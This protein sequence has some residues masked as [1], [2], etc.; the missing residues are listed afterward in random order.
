MGYHKIEPLERL[1]P[2]VESIWIQE[3]LRDASKEAF[4]PTTIIP[5]TRIDMLF[6]YRDPFWDVNGNA[7]TVFPRFFL[8][9]QK[10]KPNQVAA[11][12]QTG[13]IIFSFKPCGAFPFFKLPLN[14]CIDQSIP[15]RDIVKPERICRIEDQVLHA[16]SCFEKVVILQ[17]F[18][19]DQLEENVFDVQILRSAHQI[20]QQMGSVQIDGLARSVCLGRR[21]YE[22]RFRQSIGMS[23]QKFASVIRF[24]KALLMQQ[25]GW[26]WA[27]IIDACGYYDQ[28]HFIKEIKTYSGLSPRRILTEPQPTRLK[29]YFNNAPGM[30]QFYNT[31][32]L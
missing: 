29:S 27:D 7:K 28:S 32:Y 25:Q 15:L 8:L 20:N 16:A 3:D 24:Q 1:R 6:F 10:T 23:P 18:L 21:Q 31:L 2:Y 4:A 22:R 30:S 26:H 11:S 5:T 17:N 14:E 9:G 12:G 13:V 19:V